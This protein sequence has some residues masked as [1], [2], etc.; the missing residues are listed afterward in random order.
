MGYRPGSLAECAQA[1]V[2]KFLKI[3]HLD[4]TD[5]PQFAEM[6]RRLD[7]EFEAR[8]GYPAPRE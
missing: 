4:S 7:A 5:A 8:F 1:R 6:I 2:I 3:R